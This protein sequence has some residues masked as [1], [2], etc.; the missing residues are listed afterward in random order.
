M[1]KKHLKPEDRAVIIHLHFLQ[2]N[3]KTE[4]CAETG[5]GEK[6]VRITIRNY[7]NSSILGSNASY[8]FC[9]QKTNDENGQI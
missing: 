9:T 4:I 7:N 2:G 8:P 3:T 5:Y 1:G 6:A